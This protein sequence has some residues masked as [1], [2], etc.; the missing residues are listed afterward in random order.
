MILLLARIIR[1]GYQKGIIG[2]VVLL[3]GCTSSTTAT[4]QPTLRP[5]PPLEGTKGTPLASR[6]LDNPRGIAIDAHG[7]IVVAD[8]GTAT[9]PYSGRVVKVSSDGTTATLIQNVGNLASTQ[10]G[11]KYIF[12][13]SDVGV[14]SD[15]VYTV[16]GLGAWISSPI[17]APNRLIKLTATE[18]PRSVLDFNR[19]EQERNPDRLQLDTNASS[20]A[21]AADGTLWVSDAGGNWVAR[22]TADGAVQTVVAFPTVGGEQAVPTGLAVGPDG[23]AYV[24]LFRCQTP[25]TGKGGVARVLAN[26]QY[27][28]VASG[29][30]NPVDVAFDTRGRMY[31][32]EFAAEYAP[33][34]GRVL[35]IGAAGE[36]IAVISNLNF[37]T[38]MAFDGK[39]G[40][41]IST[42]ATPGGGDSGTGQLLHFSL[43]GR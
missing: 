7:D 41:Y 14:A 21:V 36:H 5:L 33:Q 39:D 32:L 26:G 24:A 20:V 40:L 17:F 30:N 23:S 4:R 34:S 18:K 15:G 37:P 9:Q 3:I 38:S 8:S 19:L 1:N 6:N 22:L 10:F 28:I 11:Q 25:T 27:E 12:G 43:G 31:V 16:L 13:V 29:F 42:I 2:I 35:R